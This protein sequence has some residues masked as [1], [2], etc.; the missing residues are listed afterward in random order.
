MK[1]HLW[2]SSNPERSA[3]QAGRPL[4][5]GALSRMACSRRLGFCPCV[6][7]LTVAVAVASTMPPKGSGNRIFKGSTH[8]DDWCIYHDRLAQWWEPDAQNY[9]HEDNNFGHRQWRVVGETNGH[10]SKYY[11]GSLMG[12]SPELMPLDSSLFN[13]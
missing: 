4:S 10:I 8:E 9:L 2:T 1:S 13:D 11:Q 6:L 5:A 12:D 7:L 3:G